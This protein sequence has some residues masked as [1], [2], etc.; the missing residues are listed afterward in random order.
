MDDFVQLPFGEEYV[1]FPLLVLKGIDF[2]TG[3]ITFFLFFLL[4]DGGLKQMEVKGLVPRFRRPLRTWAAC[5]GFPRPL[6]IWRSGFD[7]I[8]CTRSC[9]LQRLLVLKKPNGNEF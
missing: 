1:I 2:T 4:F 9:T 3:N 7:S 6:E 5:L 8:A